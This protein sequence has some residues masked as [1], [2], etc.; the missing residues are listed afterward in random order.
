MNNILVLT[1]FTETSRYGL[2]LAVDLAKNT[3]STIILLNLIFPASESGFSAMGDVNVHNQGEMSRFAAELMR[4][5]NKRLLEEIGRFKDENVEFLPRIEIVESDKDVEKAIKK[6]EPDALVIGTEESKSFSEYF[7]GS[8]TEKLIKIS[9]IPVISTRRDVDNYYPYNIVCA[10]DIDD[11][12]KIDLTLLRDFSEEFNSKVHLLYVLDDGISNSK[13]I[14]KMKNLADKYKINDYS[15]NT[16]KNSSAEEAIKKFSKRKSADLLALVS[17]GKTG[18]KDML[19]GS[20]TNDIVNK[21][22]I[23]VLVMNPGK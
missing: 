16:V 10:L 7:F 2:D 12:G 4:T 17:E 21:V 6:Q 9:D 5:N 1:D 14:E 18:L 23:P 22:D 11:E 20:L 3:N 13:A 8:D 15:I 19:F